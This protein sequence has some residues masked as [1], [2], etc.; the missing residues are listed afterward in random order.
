[1]EDI[2]ANAFPVAGDSIFAK[3]DHRTSGCFPVPFP[4][5]P[6]GAPCT[7]RAAAVAVRIHGRVRATA[8]S[9]ARMGVRPPTSSTAE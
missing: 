3:S 8:T 1:M 2:K 7:E 9:P 6:P 4:R 5:V